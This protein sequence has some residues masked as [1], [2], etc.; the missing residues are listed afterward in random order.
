VAPNMM[1]DDNAVSQTFGIILMIALVTVLVAI[2]AIYSLD[3]ENNGLEKS[4]Y[5]KGVVT[6]TVYRI[7]YDPDDVAVFLT[8]YHN[9]SITYRVPKKEKKL[10]AKLEESYRSQT[11]V[12][13]YYTRIGWLYQIS[14]VEYAR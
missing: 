5:G 13:I 12:E 11:H 6:D 14:S 2:I 7:Q 10:I 9:D 3:L 4:G 8:N 1:K